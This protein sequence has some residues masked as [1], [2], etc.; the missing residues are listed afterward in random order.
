MTNYVR[1]KTSRNGTLGF[2]MELTNYPCRG[3]ADCR[4]RLT[5]IMKYRNIASWSFEAIVDK[6]IAS[7][8]SGTPGAG[9]G[10]G[11]CDLL[12]VPFWWTQFLSLLKDPLIARRTHAIAAWHRFNMSY[13]AW[14]LMDIVSFKR[15]PPMLDNTFQSKNREKEP[16]RITFTSSANWNPTWKTD[17]KCIWCV[18]VLRMKTVP[19]ETL[20]AFPMLSLKKSNRSLSMHFVSRGPLA[21]RGLNAEQRRTKNC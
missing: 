3:F 17:G 7:A 21:I 11:R 16:L 10:Q 2:D 4:V 12:S 13:Y 1:Y 14:A 20:C 6:Y 15:L 18:C 9:K 5:Y 8:T 19:Y